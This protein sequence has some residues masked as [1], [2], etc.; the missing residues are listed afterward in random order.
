MQSKS[1]I[2]YHFCRVS[3]IRK[4]SAEY[5]NGGLNINGLRGQIS[6]KTILLRS[7][8]CSTIKKFQNDKNDTIPTEDRI[9][10]P[11]GGKRYRDGTLVEYI[12]KK[13]SGYI[14]GILKRI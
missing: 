6:N 2:Q 13:L 7:D 3:I 12:L 4:V 11:E 9:L 10:G 5:G 1:T 14:D 8:T